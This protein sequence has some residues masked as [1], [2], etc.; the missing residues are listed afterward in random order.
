MNAR[1]MPTLAITAYFWILLA[2]CRRS[3]S[4]LTSGYCSRD[5]DARDHSEL[6]DAARAMP[7]S[8]S[9]QR[10]AGLITINS[11]VCDAPSREPGLIL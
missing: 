3:R 5:A 2:Q 7:T 4:R 11:P 8:R 6:L 9:E 10:L 1:A